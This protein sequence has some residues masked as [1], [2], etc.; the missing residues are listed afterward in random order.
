MVYSCVLP[1]PWQNGE[2]FENN[3]VVN[4]AWVCPVTA[5]FMMYCTPEQEVVSH[6]PFTT[7]FFLRDDHHSRGTSGPFDSSC[8]ECIR[9]RQETT[10]G[11]EDPVGLGKRWEKGGLASAGDGKKGQVEIA[12][13]SKR[14]TTRQTDRKT[15]VKGRRVW[16]LV[17]FENNEII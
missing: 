11:L 10:L 5:V 12:T 6:S 4:V 8:T 9:K 14:E 1:P 15:D 17:V 16:C 7:I 3:V 2:S 13:I